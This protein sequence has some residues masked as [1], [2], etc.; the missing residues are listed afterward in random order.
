[1]R[2]TASAVTRLSP[3]SMTTSMPAAC[4]ASTA[5]GVVALTGSAMAKMP[6]TCGVDAD[7]DD[8]GTVAPQPVGL[9]EESSRVQV[10]AGQ[11][12]GAAQRHGV[13]VD[14]ADYA[15]SDG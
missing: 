13:T 1:M 6:A 4:N 12:V 14:D 7:E 15:A 9:G 10:L 2:A 5:S 3:V 11:E 8:G